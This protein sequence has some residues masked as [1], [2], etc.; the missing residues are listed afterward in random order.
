[1][2]SHE[3]FSS[4]LLAAPQDVS[5][6]ILRKLL[7]KGYD[8][9]TWRSNPGATDDVCIGRDGDEWTLGA[10]VSGLR[11]RAPIFER[12]HVGCNCKVEVSGPSLPSVII[13]AFGAQQVKKV[14]AKK[15]VAPILQ[16]EEEDLGGGPLPTNTVPVKPGKPAAKPAPKSVA[17]PKPKVEEKKVQ[18][19]KQGANKPSM[20]T[21]P[22]MAK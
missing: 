10:F 4:R 19:V 5:L 14:P 16:D 22:K 8:L 3:E 18:P 6:P 9:V 20:A 12:T 17:A 21:K 13:D 11:H 15:A 7:R 1:M 2:E